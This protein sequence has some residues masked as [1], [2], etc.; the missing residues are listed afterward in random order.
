VD[1]RDRAVAGRGIVDCED[2]RR[3]QVWRPESPCGTVERPFRFT[4]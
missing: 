4:D 2:R 3:T 1:E